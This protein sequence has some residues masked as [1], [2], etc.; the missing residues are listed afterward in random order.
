[1]NFSYAVLRICFKYSYL[2][3]PTFAPLPFSVFIFFLFKS[4]LLAETNLILTKVGITF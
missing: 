4:L 3:S 1:M 2:A